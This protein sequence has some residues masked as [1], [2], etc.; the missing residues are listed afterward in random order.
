M[1]DQP[2]CPI[3]GPRCPPSICDCFIDLYPD[4]PLGIHPEAFTVMVPCP[5]CGHTGLI[6][7]TRCPNCDPENTP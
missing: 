6:G 5:N 2:G 3:G 7:G 4:D 1:S